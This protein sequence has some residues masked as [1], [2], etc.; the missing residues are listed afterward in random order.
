M[1]SW[2]RAWTRTCSTQVRKPQISLDSRR[3][4][5]LEVGCRPSGRKIRKNVTLT[6][7]LVLHLGDHKTGSTAIQ[8]A[9]A[10][11]AWRCL[12]GLDAV[13][14][15]TVL[16][17]AAVDHNQLAQSL[18][19]SDSPHQRRNRFTN[20]AR[21]IAASEADIAVLSAEEFERVNPEVLHEALH[22]Y[23]PDLADQARLIA[24]VRPHADRLL[25][26]YAERVKQGYFL[27]SLTEFH[28]KIKDSRLL[29]YAPRFRKWRAVFGER[30]EL[31]PMIR[32][33]LHNNCV[34]QDF[35][36]FLLKGAAFEL[37]RPAENNPSLSLED[38][39]MLRALQLR[40]GQGKIPPHQAQNAIGWKFAILLAEAGA[41]GGTR[42]RPDRALVAEMQADCRKDAAALD[43]EFFSGRPMAEALD[44]AMDGAVDLPQ[45][46]ELESCFQADELHR[47]KGWIELLYR[48]YLRQPEDWPR[49]M[50][51]L[52]N[53]SE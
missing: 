26:S 38:L 50:R 4:T 21:L 42:L 37:T 30:F 39:A 29:H 1:S 9:L 33:G 24:Y 7:E 40:L 43:A 41:A 36:H 32:A 44:R 20:H 6:R 23:F 35:L 31:R 14:G 17:T 46:L 45:S 49:H 19:D 47:I 12:S 5:S 11:Q 13:P 10:D 52:G 28:S 22:R 3:K 51:R 16:Y 18:L 27:G 48:M 34:V 15:I 8:K 25:S 2:R 53:P